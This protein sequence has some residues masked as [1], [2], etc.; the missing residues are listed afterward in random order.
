MAAWRRRVP[1]QRCDFKKQGLDRNWST[2]AREIHFCVA[3]LGHQQQSAPAFHLIRA[4]ANVTLC[5]KYSISSKRERERRTLMHLF[6]GLAARVKHIFSHK[7]GYL[8]TAQS[9]SYSLTRPSREMKLRRTNFTNETSLSRRARVM[10]ERLR[11]NYIF[12]LR[13]TP[14]LASSSGEVLAPAADFYNSPACSV[15]VA[16]LFPGIYY[17]IVSSSF[18]R[19]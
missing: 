1:R 6:L 11:P 5:V 14:A 12:H 18:A 13:V 7:P 15:T 16:C 8:F 17:Y 10:H 3:K 4:D 9:S 19:L 2:R